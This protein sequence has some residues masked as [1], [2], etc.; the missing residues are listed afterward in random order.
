[1]IELSAPYAG[2][3]PESRVELVAACTRNEAAAQVRQCALGVPPL[4][5]AVKVASV[6]GSAPSEVSAAAAACPPSEV[7]A[8]G[9]ALVVKEGLAQ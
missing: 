6:E 8:Q 1:M 9:P 3:A 7:D 4:A 2:S 5:G